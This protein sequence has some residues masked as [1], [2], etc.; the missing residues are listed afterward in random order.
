MT[1]AFYDSMRSGRVIW[2]TAKGIANHWKAG[3]RD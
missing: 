2:L 1:E 3:A